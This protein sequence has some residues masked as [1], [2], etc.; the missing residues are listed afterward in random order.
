MYSV[1]NSGNLSRVLGS[2]MEL[3]QAKSLRVTA[4][5][6]SLLIFTVVYGVLYFSKRYS[7]KWLSALQILLTIIFLFVLIQG[8]FKVI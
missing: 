7:V 8:Y 4:F 6:V 5:L 3:E 2:R 1:E